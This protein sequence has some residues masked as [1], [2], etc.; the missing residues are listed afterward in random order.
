MLDQK[1]AQF[2][3][4]VAQK[5]APMIFLKMLLFSKYSKK[6]QNS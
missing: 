4:K 6:S 2:L 3:T 5:V 1:V